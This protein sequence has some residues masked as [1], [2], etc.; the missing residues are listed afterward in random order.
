MHFDS[1]LEMINN[2]TP[3]IAESI[4]PSIES[5]IENHISKFDC[6][7]RLTGLLYGQVQS[8][9]TGQMLGAIT[10]SADIDFRLF[11]LLT[12]DNVRLQE[13]TLQRALETLDTFN[14]CGENDDLRFRTGKLRRPT[15]IILKKNQSVLRRWHD[16][17]ASSG[18]C[19]ENPI[20]IVDDE[21][22]NASLN[23]RINQSEQSTINR[24]L[25]NIKQLSR[26]S[27]YLQVT[28]T[29]Q[30]VLL[31]RLESDWS[32]DFT[33]YFEPG[34]GYLGGNF[35][36]S[37]NSTC[38]KTTDANERTLLLRNDNNIPE[39]FRKAFW[40]F[41]VSGAH[42]IMR[43]NFQVSNFLIHPGLRIHEHNI[44]ERKIRLLLGKIRNDLKQDANI[45]FCELRD[46]WEDINATKEGLIE[47]DFLKKEIENILDR[48]N[49]IVV[50]SDSDADRAFA[51][52]MNIVIGGNSLGRG[53]TLPR[54]HAVYYCRIAQTPQA[55]TC[56]QHS[57]IFGYDRDPDLCRIFLPPTLLTLFRELDE[58]NDALAGII[59]DGRQFETYSILSPRG[60]RPTRPSVIERGSYDIWYGGANYFPNLPLPSNLGELDSLLGSIDMQKNV[61]LRLAK[62]VVRLI[63]TESDEP[64]KK[65][66]VLSHLLALE[67]SGYARGCVLIIRV[68]RNIS[69]GTGTLLSPDDRRLTQSYP[70][71]LILVVYRING[72]RNE[73]WEDSPL[74]IPN[75]KFPIGANYVYTV[76]D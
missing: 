43:E 60:T 47:F 35:F 14:I 40:S 74:W 3:G 42:L 62:Q 55:D 53:L 46:V 27:I 68:G 16:I 50:N 54:L 36:Y 51:D 25:E 73:G 20:F 52:G 30:S 26:S 44:T 48:I 66:I 41:L 37:E 59:K 22:D 75:I 31:Q 34:S 32:P 13:Q 63:E 70:D 49:I 45:V 61:D 24:L 38:L 76:S 4:R 33:Y 11:I 58:A 15:L 10:A 56:W 8:G 39:G 1:Y 28:A 23:T 18:F 69:K 2:N 64:W 19:R 65:E 5:F 67:S 6:M 17:I 72:G 21:A 57:R 7:S 29:P 9:K 71:R 12:T